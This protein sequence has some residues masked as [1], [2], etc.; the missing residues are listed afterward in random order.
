[1]ESQYD[2][3]FGQVTEHV[4]QASLLTWHDID[5]GTGNALSTT[6]VVGLDDRFHPEEGDDVT[7]TYSYTNAACEGQRCRV[8]RA[9]KQPMPPRRASRHCNSLVLR[10]LWRD[11]PFPSTPLCRLRRSL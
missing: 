1:V 3:N 4:D 9:D 2:Q 5:L 6:R 7:T 10:G 11:S 8:A